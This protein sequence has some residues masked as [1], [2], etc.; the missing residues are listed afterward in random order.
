[1][2]DSEEDLEEGSVEELEEEPALEG[3]AASE[4]E[5]P[6]Q[7]ASDEWCR[8]IPA[9]ASGRRRGRPVG[10]LGSKKRMRSKVEEEV[11]FYFFQLFLEFVKY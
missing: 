8:Q 9:A 7:E 2:V 1:M 11:S 3:T 5:E 6:S 10:S 4:V